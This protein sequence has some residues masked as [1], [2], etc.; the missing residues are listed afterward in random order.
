MDR[1]SFMGTVAI[2]VMSGPLKADGQATKAGRMGYLS[3]A[4]RE[5]T[6]AAASTVQARLAELGY[7]EGR[8]LV[9]DFRHADTEARLRDHALELVGNGVQV[10]FAANP[11]AIRAARAATATVP[12]V[13]YDLE[14]DPVVAGFAASLARPGGNVTGVFLDQGELNGKQLQILKEMQPG[15]SR[16]A[17]RCEHDR[18]GARRCASRRS[19]DRTAHSL[20]AGHQPGHGQSARARRSTGV[21][22]AR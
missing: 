2:V 10:I 16:V 17:H 6:P 11:Y 9:V 21:A 22:A 12:I 1:R 14:T 15:L 18:Q 20:L 4:P 5:A 13:G 19:S 8:N 3:L 7:V